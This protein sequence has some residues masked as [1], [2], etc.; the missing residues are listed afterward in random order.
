MSRQ[1]SQLLEMLAVVLASEISNVARIQLHV[2]GWLNIRQR[3]GFLFEEKYLRGTCR[4]RHVAVSN[5]NFPF[6]RLG[7]F[8]VNRETFLARGDAR[9]RGLQK[10]QRQ[11][12]LF[13]PAGGYRGNRFSG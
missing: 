5:W 1:R 13:R 4:A 2:L 6:E 11:T 10:N 3:C 8:L 9:L 12:G 7:A